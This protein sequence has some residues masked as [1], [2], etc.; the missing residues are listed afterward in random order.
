MSIDEA[1]EHCEQIA[2]DNNCECADEHRQLAEWLKELREY[3]TVSRK[4]VDDAER[5][6][7]IEC[8]IQFREPIKEWACMYWLAVA[9]K[10]LIEWAIKQEAAKKRECA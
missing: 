6:E 7:N 8:K 9:V 3:K 10:H 2:G 5:M 4:W 1:I